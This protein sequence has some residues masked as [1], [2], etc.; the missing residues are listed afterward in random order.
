MSK[1][2]NLM[3]IDH[4]MAG[5]ESVA[6]LHS[7]YS[8]IEAMRNVDEK[9]LRRLLVREGAEDPLALRCHKISLA[10]HYA[11]LY[12]PAVNAHHQFQRVEGAN[13]VVRTRNRSG[14]ES[15]SSLHKELERA[16]SNT[17]FFRYSLSTHGRH[18]NDHSP[19]RIRYVIKTTYR[20]VS[21]VL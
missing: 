3:A 13:V 6:G 14:A 17:P 5:V 21:T 19:D 8:V 2:V 15:N 20:H 7:Q 9:F 16:Y 4:V 11:R 1:D 10:D 18:R 12:G